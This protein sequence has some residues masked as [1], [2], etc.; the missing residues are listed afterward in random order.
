MEQSRTKNCTEHR[1]EHRTEQNCLEQN[2]EWNRTEQNCAER[3]GTEQ[4]KTQNRT[5]N[6][7]EVFRRP[8][9][10]VSGTLP[11]V[12]TVCLKWDHRGLMTLTVFDLAPGCRWDREKL[13]HELV[14]SDPGTSNESFIFRAGG[15]GSA[16]RRGANW[17]FRA[18]SK[19]IF[20]LSTMVC[21]LESLLSN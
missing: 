8:C 11:A 9:V 10:S 5:Q 7:T 4:N 13:L 15:T 6:R 18:Q 16:W 14:L 21:C 17:S 20:C 3:N 19:S 1:T 12:E 2:I